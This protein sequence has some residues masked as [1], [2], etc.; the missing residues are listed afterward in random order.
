MGNNPST[1]TI[2]EA[3]SVVNQIISTVV[4]T[5][6][7]SAVVTIRGNQVTKLN[8][9]GS[10]DFKCPDGVNIC[11]SN[12]SDIS[13][14]MMTNFKS[15][16]VTQIKNALLNEITNENSQ[17]MK[18]VKGFL[19][20]L[21]AG[22]SQQNTTNVRNMISNYINNY[23][24]ITTIQSSLQSITS[25]QQDE[26]N[27]YGN[28]LFEGS[29]CNLTLTNSFQAQQVM[30]AIASSIVNNF[31]SN[32]VT[33]D[34]VN[35][36]SQTID[37]KSEGIE[38]A[39]YAAAALAIA[40]GLF[41][42]LQ[43]IGTRIAAKG[44]QGGAAPENKTF[45][46]L[47]TILFIVVIIGII[48]FWLYNQYS[49]KNWPFS[50]SS[51]YGCKLGTFTDP[52]TGK[53]MIVNA[54]GCVAYSK[55]DNRGIYKS[56]Q[57]CENKTSDQNNGT[58]GQ[59]WGCQFDNNKKLV[60]GCAQYPS[61]YYTI[62]WPDN[63]KTQVNSSFVTQQD[64]NN[65]SCP[66]KWTCAVDSN[67]F[68]VEGQCRLITDAVE[69]ANISQLYSTGNDTTICSNNTYPNSSNSNTIQVPLF[70]TSDECVNAKA[71]ATTWS[72]VNPGDTTGNSCSQSACPLTCTST[73]T[74]CPMQLYSTKS[75]CEQSC[76]SSSSLKMA[77]LTASSPCFSQ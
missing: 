42:V 3:T 54:G 72:C 13:S 74:N 33:N 66:Q 38:S 27:M 12:S 69:I 44:A 41:Y 65:T 70:D 34:V 39:M 14:Q 67:G 68:N 62:N 76:G 50:P 46:R 9:T 55:N 5:T 61:A 64:C 10:F 11:L 35:R 30:N 36:A 47:L 1:N 49:K 7:Q 71:C 8:M 23:I 40:C 17:L 15:Q 73:D 21:N 59:F 20:S 26:M 4:S 24:N 52:A 75:A 45:S 18:I 22:S 57:E 32:S 16:A 58:C 19:S 53:Q 28:Y 77:G 43:G 2:N 31:V 29:S 37:V 48:G 25:I 63:T 6:N 56:Q 51:Y 60:N